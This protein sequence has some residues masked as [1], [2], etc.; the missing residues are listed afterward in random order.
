[1]FQLLQNVWSCPEC[2][3]RH[4]V[5]VKRSLKFGFVQNVHR[6]IWF[7]SK[8]ALMWSCWKCPWVCL[9]YA[10]WYLI[11]YPAQNT[12]ALKMSLGSKSLYWYLWLIELI[13]KKCYHVYWSNNC[14]VATFQIMTLLASVDWLVMALGVRWML[15]GTNVTNHF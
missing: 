13:H 2:P 12:Q 11:F 8:G 1:M 7:T 6:D 9:V 3:Q 14:I 15:G 4:L 10:K 5:R